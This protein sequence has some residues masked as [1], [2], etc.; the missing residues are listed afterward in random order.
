[1][2]VLTIAIILPAAHAQTFQIL[3]NFTGFADGSVPEDSVTIDRSGNLYGTSFQGTAFKLSRAG[4]GWVLTTLHTFGIGSDGARPAS[5]VVFGPDGTLYGTTSAGGSNGVGTVYNL[6]PPA[7]VCRSTQCPWTETVLHN[8]SGSDG[9][10]PQLG[11][12]VFDAAGNAYGTTSGGGAHG[13]G[14]VFEL[15]RSGSSWTQNVLYS[16]AGG[17]DGA[18]PYSGVILD[19]AGNL[20][21]TTTLGGAH[22]LGAVYELSPSPSGWS[23]TILHS[24][25][26]SDLSF[27]PYGGLVF[28]PQG[29]LYGTAYG[30]PN[31][32]G[33]V[34]EL[35]PSDGAWNYSLVY[36]FSGYAGPHDAPT[37]D[38]SG[39]I[40]LTN[41][42]TG[43]E[44]A[45][46]VFKL[47]PG[48]GGWTATD[49]YDFNGA[50]TGAAPFGGV[51]LD[52]SGNV[53]GTTT[54]GGTSNLGIVFEITP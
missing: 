4:S 48:V 32:G 40:F 10:A 52:T 21:G 9:A 1:M 51:T 7:T 36:G 42:N 23:E 44:Q 49:L 31:Q 14:V 8:F 19:A 34:Y 12:L 47:T 50:R 35:V 45:G 18:I 26:G 41:L 27:T 39:D 15:S 16:F 3:H 25:G 33:T 2:L 29:N 13:E 30:G 20:Y 6:R 38:A 37:L 22:S 53:Y 46:S 17:N 54:L 11:N 28:D 24:F 43:P 5:G